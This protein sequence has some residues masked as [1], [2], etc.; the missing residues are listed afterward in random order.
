M[1]ALCTSYL[2]SSIEQFFRLQASRRARANSEPMQIA[3]DRK[4]CFRSCW[5]VGIVRLVAG[6]LQSAANWKG[7]TCPCT[8][9]DV[10][11]CGEIT[12]NLTLFLFSDYMRCML[13]YFADYPRSC[14]NGVL[15]FPKINDA[16]M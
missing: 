10:G 9:D 6:S 16:G 1:E 11:T 7:G 8:I 15:G 3:V 13:V 12:G 5:V 4:I 2:G 14:E